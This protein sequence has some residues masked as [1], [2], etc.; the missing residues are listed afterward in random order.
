[1]DYI[2]AN[3]AMMVADDRLTR[4]LD[5]ETPECWIGPHRLKLRYYNHGP[6]AVTFHWVCPWKYHARINSD[7]VVK[8]D[9]QIIRS[10]EPS[11]RED[12]NLLVAWTVKRGRV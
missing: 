12:S 4:I 5:G 3:A 6:D 10:L 9:G 1:M 2:R 7:I 8:L 11:Y